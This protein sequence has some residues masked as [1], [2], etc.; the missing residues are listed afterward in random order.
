M[1]RALTPCLA[2]AGLL[3]VVPA[4]ALTP[5]QEKMKSCNA[6]AGSQRLTGAVRKTFVTGCLKGGSG[7]EAPKPLTAQQE[8][9]KS[10]NADATTK[11]LQGKER[12][13]FMASCLKG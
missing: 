12:R 2:I 13:T 7:A 10:C 4:W 5:Q 9:M 8:K 3:A 6:D 11:T 1:I